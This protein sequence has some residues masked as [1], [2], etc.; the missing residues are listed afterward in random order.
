MAASEIKTKTNDKYSWKVKNV[1]YK[2]WT[3]MFSL[4]ICT[5]IFLMFL[6]R[7]VWIASN[8]QLKANYM[9]TKKNIYFKTRFVLP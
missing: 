1:K 6:I 3:L 9:P 7:L 5:F 2:S 4:R 8:L